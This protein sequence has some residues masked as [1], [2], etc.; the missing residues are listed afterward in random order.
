MRLKEETSEIK[1]HSGILG[2]EELLNSINNAITDIKSEFVA[3]KISDSCIRIYLTK[4]SILTIDYIYNEKSP[5]VLFTDY[6]GIKDVKDYR[7]P[8]DEKELI[9]YICEYLIGL[10]LTEKETIVI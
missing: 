2:V 9:D 8:E 3:V 6:K 7:L 5:Y 4:K 1:Y 10:N